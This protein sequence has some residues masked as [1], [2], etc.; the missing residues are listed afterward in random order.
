MIQLLLGLSVE[1]TN[2]ST[3]LDDSADDI[4]IVNLQSTHNLSGP[5]EVEGAEAGDMLV[6][7]AE[8]ASFTKYSP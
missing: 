3:C 1:L 5:I 7:E 8:L 2:A 4:H 6:G